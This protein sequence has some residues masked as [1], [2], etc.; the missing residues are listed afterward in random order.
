MKIFSVRVGVGA[1]VKVGFRV[2]VRIGVGVGVGVW[3]FYD[4]LP[5]PR[6]NFSILLSLEVVYTAALLY[7]S[8]LDSLPMPLGSLPPEHRSNLLERG[9]VYLMPLEGF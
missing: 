2:R 9:A 8:G 4:G 5:Q 6:L 7:E 3:G 1:E